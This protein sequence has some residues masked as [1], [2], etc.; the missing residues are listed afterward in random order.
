M[1]AIAIQQPFAS[2]IALGI[3]DVWSMP[4]A[5]D[6]RGRVLIVAKNHFLRKS[7]VKKFP[8]LWNHVLYNHDMLNN[9]GGIIWDDIQPTCYPM[10]EIV[11]YA[12]VVDCSKN[13]D[14]FSDSFWYRDGI[15]W[16]FVNSHYNNAAGWGRYKPIN[17]SKRGLY[18]IPK[19]AVK[20][21]CD[22]VKSK[23]FYPYFNGKDLY[24][25]QSID[26]YY[27]ENESDYTNNTTTIW[28]YA[29]DPFMQLALTGKI[30]CTELLPCR[31]VY[32]LLE[33]GDH[34]TKTKFVKSYTE[35]DRW[36]DL[37]F[38]IVIDENNWKNYPVETINKPVFED[39]EKEEYSLD[40]SGS[41][42]SLNHKHLRCACYNIGDYTIPEGVEEIDD[43]ACEF[44]DG[45]TSVIIPDSVKRI[46]H[47]AF[48]H[49]KDLHT[50]QLGKGIEEIED[51]AFYGC[52]KLKH[53]IIPKGYKEHFC[54][55]DSLREV[56]HLIIEK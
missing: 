2:F 17:W 14:N 32:H 10:G 11:G 56:K 41:V 24:L 48:Q 44:C 9:L 22:F 16:R 36:G 47:Q 19:K 51:Y 13:P 55:I 7:G 31:N 45:L 54:E 3:I 18:E 26:A 33:Q 42:Y 25:Q 30:G 49:C 37:C 27:N 21:E 53:I 35:K 23:P 8:K 5:T 29:D 39:F 6:Y 1:K 12:D 38:K 40:E 52:E 34:Y 28:F 46:G 43:E 50:I 20:E 15:T 4:F